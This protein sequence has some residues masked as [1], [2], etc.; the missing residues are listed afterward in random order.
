MFQAGILANYGTLFA[1]VPTIIFLIV[2]IYQIIRGLI[3]GFRKSLVLMIFSVSTLAIAL[4]LVF[5]VF[6]QS[7]FEEFIVKTFNIKGSLNVETNDNTFGGVINAFV[8]Q[9][10]EGTKFDYT[11]S[12]LSPYVIALAQSILGLVYLFICF[13]LW[14]FFYWLFYF[15]LYLTIFSERK[16]IRKKNKKYDEEHQ[17]DT[18]MEAESNN[19]KSKKQYKYRGYKRHRGF[20]ALIG[21]LRGLLTASLSICLFGT[22][23]YLATGMKT[24]VGKGNEEVKIVLNDDEYDLT[25]VYDFIYEYDRTGVNFI[26]DRIT[27]PSGMPLYASI[28]S[29]FTSAKIVV[30]E[31]GIKTKIYPVEEVGNV[32]NVFHSVIELA[33]KYKFLSDKDILSNLANTIETDE[34][35]SN[36]VL[37][38]AKKITK[39][40]IADSLSKTISCHFVEILD[41]LDIKNK[42]I[43]TIFKGEN[44]ITLLD[45]VN[46]DDLAQVVKIALTAVTV[47]DD[48]KETKDIKDLLINKTN[49]VTKI[50]DEIQGLYLFNSSNSSKINNIINDLLGTALSSVEQLKGVNFT[51]VDWI[52]TDSNPKGELN[53][54]LD[55]VISVIDSGLLHYENS[56]I[57]YNFSKSSTILKTQEI[58]N[59]KALRCVLS[60][61]LENQTIGGNKIYLP[62]NC[63]D[64]NKVL[65]ESSM[66]SLFDSM[67]TL[68]DNFN[69]TD[70]YISTSDL[71]TKVL[72]KCVASVKN[73]INALNPILD[74]EIL[75]SIFAKYAYD[76]LSKNYSNCIA[77]DLVLDDE[78]I[79]NNINNWVGEGKEIELVVKASTEL[80]SKEV[81]SID[82][83]NNKVTY[84]LSKIS[85]L[86]EDDSSKLMT[87]ATNSLLLRGLIPN[88]LEKIDSGS[89]I[90][91]NIPE[92][93]YTLDGEV[94]IVNSDEMKS[95]FKTLGTVCSKI[96]ISEVSD[97]NSMINDFISLVK[98]DTARHKLC[99]SLILEATLSK[100]LYD[101]ISTTTY[102]ANIPSD[103]V[104]DEEHYDANIKNWY[105]ENKEY[106]KLIESLGAVLKTDMISISSTDGTTSI[107]YNINNVNGLFIGNPEPVD[108][109]LESRVIVSIMSNVITSMDIGYT[110]YIPDSVKENGII[111]AE[112]MKNML[113]ACATITSSGL[114]F[115]STNIQEDV[116]S[117][118]TNVCKDDA[119]RE[120]LLNSIIMAGTLSNAIY[121]ITSDN[122]LGVSFQ[123]PNNLN[124]SDS[125]NMDNW[126][127]TNGELSKILKVLAYVDIANINGIDFIFNL[128]ESQINTMCDSQIFAKT[129]TYEIKN[130]SITDF[131]LVTLSSCYDAND[132]IIS[133]EVYNM[134]NA[135][136]KISKYDNL[137]EEEKTA[138][139]FTKVEIDTNQV[140]NDNEILN[141]IYNSKILEASISLKVYDSIKDNTSVTVPTNLIILSSTED[142]Y[143]NWMGENKELRNIINSLK[144]L[145]LLSD[146]DAINVNT[147]CILKDNLNLD[148][149]LASDIIYLTVSNNMKTESS[150]DIPKIAYETDSDIIKKEEIKKVVVSAKLLSTDNTIENVSANNFLNLTEAQI[151]TVIDSSILRYTTSND[152]IG[153]GLQTPEVVKE[154]IL[155]D[156]FIQEEEIVNTML[157]LQA[158]GSDSV[159]LVIIDNESFLALEDEAK[160]NT[161]LNSYLAWLEVSGQIITGVTDSR[162]PSDA[163]DTSIEGSQKYIYKTEIQALLKSLRTLGIT[164]INSYSINGDK[165]F[166]ITDIEALLNSKIVW[167]GFSQN[168]KS[169]EELVVTKQS[170]YTANN[171]YI[172]KDEISYLIDGV[173][174]GNGTSLSSINYNPQNLDSLKI[175]TSSILRDTIAKILFYD[176]KTN[177]MDDDISIVATLKDGEK[178]YT[179]SYDEI[180]ALLTGLKLLGISDFKTS[181]LNFSISQ[182]KSI[183]D[184]TVRET[185]LNSTTIWIYISQLVTDIGY[186]GSEN[187]DTIQYNGTQVIKAQTLLI[188]KEEIISL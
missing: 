45:I 123:I 187:L 174:S 136:K 176:N 98:D 141:S 50:L 77:S 23:F 24:D 103:L 113:K 114:D 180:N 131:T 68:I 46:K 44:A 129:L 21:V 69:L 56:K 158:L 85:I 4:I 8:Y 185:I 64:S 126:I 35:F 116:K 186:T 122:S 161:I 111:V 74:S 112:E 96:N 160:I 40:K 79:A 152:I 16:Y 138:F 133:S 173:K 121:S 58:S 115:N 28:P 165:L 59:S 32:V 53:I 104:L 154:T 159:E 118:L 183:S 2:F 30:K 95:L 178:F 128:D 66:V 109:V 61:F 86:T 130:A 107:D 148:I 120:K 39:S 47:Y 12:V 149:V 91:F 106:R 18:T 92:G 181:G 76:M 5:L 3:R 119:N 127:S 72:D 62:S 82:I 27:L 134:L 94:K 99:G 163:Y 89:A 147:N 88:L 65:T 60:A 25:E 110:I 67:A 14:Q 73:N 38:I 153:C 83:T 7:F 150:I 166:N 75:Q 143:D 117:V 156:L 15:T 172:K 177:S 151:R 169:N 41:S 145:D 155:E 100:V 11:Y 71:K 102:G 17:L 124:L 101:S 93:A 70:E 80:L 1:W 81:I 184:S 31:D 168:I 105:G 42:Y 144:E 162:M 179:Y 146:I 29:L 167:F 139:D 37:S 34:N 43:D 33:S 135:V 125:S 19:K 48:Y 137:T 90:S 164:N 170:L 10:V 49:S 140:L 13:I 171:D 175:A 188:T 9:K 36:E 78:H 97:T 22:I 6:K 55:T 51:G 54:F 142:N 157:A 26:Y 84:D 87:V 108:T 20:G 52:K 57:T 182:F 63:Y 132:N